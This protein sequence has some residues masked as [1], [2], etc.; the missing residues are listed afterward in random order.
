MYYVLHKRKLTDTIVS[1]KLSEYITTHNMSELSISDENLSILLTKTYPYTILQHQHVKCDLQDYIIVLMEHCK[2]EIALL[3]YESYSYV[4]KTVGLKYYEKD[5]AI[6]NKIIPAKSN[7]DVFL[8]INPF[9]FFKTADNIVFIKIN[10]QTLAIFNLDDKKESIIVNVNHELQINYYFT[11][12]VLKKFTLPTLAILLEDKVLIFSFDDRLFIKIDE[13][14]V[15]E[16]TFDLKGLVNGLCYVSLKDIKQ[17]LFEIIILPLYN[18]K[19]IVVIEVTKFKGWCV[20]KDDV[21]IFCEDGLYRL[22]IIFN[23]S[24]VMKYNLIKLFDGY[25]DSGDVYDKKLFVNSSKDHSYLFD[26]TW[27]KRINDVVCDFEDVKKFDTFLVNKPLEENINLFNNDNKFNVVNETGILDNTLKDNFKDITGRMTNIDKGLEEK[28]P[29]TT[30][31]DIYTID[32]NSECIKKTDVLH[33][34]Y[35]IKNNQDIYSPYIKNT[36]NQ[37]LFDEIYGFNSNINDTLNN[38]NDKNM[39]HELHNG[40]REHKKQCNIACDSNH[41]GGVKGFMRILDRDE[42]KNLDNKNMSVHDASL[43]VYENDGLNLMDK[44]ELNE[45]LLNVISCDEKINLDHIVTTNNIEKCINDDTQIKIKQKSDHFAYETKYNDYMKNTTTKFN[46]KEAVKKNRLDERADVNDITIYK[47]NNLINEAKNEFKNDINKNNFKDFAQSSINKLRLSSK[48][49]NE[50]HTNL[51]IYENIQIK[52]Y[53][54]LLENKTK[55]YN[56]KINAITKTEKNFT[57]IGYKK[58]MIFKENIKLN[59]S[60]VI[61]IKNFG[62]FFSA[63]RLIC[64]TNEKETFFLDYKPESN[65]STKKETK[66]VKYSST[67]LFTKQEDTNNELFKNCPLACMSTNPQPIN[68]NNNISSKKDNGNNNS[69]I[70]LKVN[71]NNIYDEKVGTLNYKQNENL[72]RNLAENNYY[73]S[74]LLLNVKNKNQI[75]NS[76]IILGDAKRERTICDILIDDVNYNNVHNIDNISIKTKND[77]KAKSQ[78]KPNLKNN[79]TYKTNYNDGY[80]VCDVLDLD[81][82]P[83]SEINKKFSNQSTNIDDSKNSH[84]KLDTQQANTNIDDVKFLMTEKTMYFSKYKNLH[85]QITCNKI[86]YN[87]NEL[88]FDTKIIKAINCE[89]H[90]YVLFID[91]IMHVYNG[92]KLIIKIQNVSFFSFCDDLVF[93][94]YKNELKI[95]DKAQLYKYDPNNYETDNIQYLDTFALQKYKYDDLEVMIS[96]E[97]H[98]NIDNTINDYINKENYNKEVKKIRNNINY[99]TNSQN[100]KDF[101]GQNI[102]ESRVEKNY[103]KEDTGRKKN[104]IKDNRNEDNSMVG[105]KLYKNNE[106]DQNYKNYFSEH[107]INFEAYENGENKQNNKYN[108]F[109]LDKNNNI[110]NI[111]ND[112]DIIYEDIKDSKHINIDEDYENIHTDKFCVVNNDLKN[113][114]LETFKLLEN[115]NVKIKNNRTKKWV[116]VALKAKNIY[117]FYAYKSG[118]LLHLPTI[119]FLAEENKSFVKLKNCL[120][121]FPDIFLFFYHNKLYTHKINRTITYIDETYMISKGCL[122]EYKFDPC[123]YYNE[124]IVKEVKIETE[125]LFIDFDKDNCMYAIGA[126]KEDYFDKDNAEEV[127]NVNDIIENKNANEVRDNFDNEFGNVYDIKNNV[128]SN[129]QPGLDKD[130]DTQQA[131]FEINNNLI[132]TQEN[133]TKQ[134]TDLCFNENELN[135]TSL[136]HSNSSCKI[137]NDQN[138]DDYKNKKIENEDKVEFNIQNFNS[139]Y[140]PEEDIFNAENHIMEKNDNKDISIYKLKNING[141]FLSEDNY[142]AENN[143]AKKNNNNIPISVIDNGDSIA[144][145]DDVY[146]NK[147]DKQLLVE[148]NYGFENKELIKIHSISLLDLSFKKIDSYDLLRN[149]YLTD[150][151]F[152]KLNSNVKTNIIAEEYYSF[153]LVALTNTIGGLRKTTK[154]RIIVFDIKNIQS[155]DKNIKEKKLFPL[156]DL[157]LKTNTISFQTI[158]GNLAICQGTRIMIYKFDR[159]NGLT[160][161]AFHDMH[162]FST[163]LAVIKNYLLVTDILKGVS[164][165]YFQNKPV[166]IHK[167]SSSEDIKNV[168]HTFFIPFGNNLLMA[169]FDDR[170]MHLYTYSPKNIYSKAGEKLI[171]RIDADLRDTVIGSGTGYFYSKSMIYKIGRESDPEDFNNWELN[172]GNKTNAHKS[173]AYKTN[174]NRTN[175]DKTIV[176]G[177]IITNSKINLYT[178]LFKDKNYYLMNQTALRM[179]TVKGIIDF[180]MLKDDLLGKVDYEENDIIFIKNHDI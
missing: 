158:R 47:Q 105:N 152:V 108:F 73:I 154:G 44:C 65:L 12:D 130:D 19:N 147:E 146:K 178:N 144:K 8:H 102:K 87:K 157:K 64:L 51:S 83:R 104:S 107:N 141:S 142:N 75:G 121:L 46:E 95:F 176:Y 110:D 143:L 170:N 155:L 74:N 23:V 163:S 171:K 91:S 138:I 1:L 34:K 103:A 59:L 156:A 172:E 123:D 39:T 169:V 22:E 109:D 116:L 177:N 150:L 15:K 120:F 174:V 36:D 26:I 24:Y 101:K 175:V 124:Y 80:E 71:V 18:L 131:I 43:D 28:I 56:Y 50:L 139:S 180:R 54:L 79:S 32:Y 92:L 97:C 61:K 166:K 10:D 9:C 66:H 57:G 136:Q 38:S 159:L 7:L 27:K 164:F 125:G 85:L 98:R 81:I 55:L 6:H 140:L 179:K 3:K 134:T 117:Y 113:K 20:C 58:I 67:E 49:C 168:F 126:I 94:L 37:N 119:P 165:F 11:F 106:D 148:N 16:N 135:K 118:K 160:A 62:S 78:L 149:E 86:L 4:L 96:N 68:V 100:Y 137:N 99:H 13:F 42:P 76:C 93:I 89:Y 88:S 127:V 84:I 29:L 122:M 111:N 48:N 151:K 45:K 5:I 114:S 41:D 167:L 72:Y 145:K 70:S 53:D 21:F 132:K 60:N 112:N 2:I 128:G 35:E 31:D 33:E 30:F 25:C 82:N 69:N 173:N 161:I 14:T 63:G 40:H 77:E 153:F 162:I 17:E 133:F 52:T 90:I 129:C 115:N